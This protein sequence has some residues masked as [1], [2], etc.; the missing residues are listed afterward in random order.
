M[1]GG[2]DFYSHASSKDQ[3]MELA[4]CINQFFRN[5]NYIDPRSTIQYEVQ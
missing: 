3:Q 4:G 5:R 1:L 2:A